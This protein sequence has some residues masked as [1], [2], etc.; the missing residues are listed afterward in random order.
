MSKLDTMLLHVDL[1]VT[2]LKGLLPRRYVRPLSQ[3]TH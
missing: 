1:R 2:G 3:L